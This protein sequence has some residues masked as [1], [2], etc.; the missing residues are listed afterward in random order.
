MNRQSKEDKDRLIELDRK[1]ED[2]LKKISSFD[3]K[4]VKASSNDD[5]NPELVWYKKEGDA[6]IS[7]THERGSEFVDKVAENDDEMIDVIIWNSLFY[8]AFSHFLMH[9]EHDFKD[10][11]RHYDDF[12]EACYKIALPSKTFVR[13]EKYND[14][15][16]AKLDSKK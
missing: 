10:P 9:R 4:I 2:I 1:A 11:Y 12:M 16:Y 15:Y 13:Q 5:T 14:E 7:I 3:I 6:W 8:Y